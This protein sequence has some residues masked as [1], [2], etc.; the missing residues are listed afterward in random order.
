MPIRSFS[1]DARKRGDGEGFGSDIENIGGEIV[2][3]VPILCLDDIDCKNMKSSNRIR[4][5]PDSNG[6]QV[7]MS[8]GNISIPNQITAENIVLTSDEKMKYQIKDLPETHLKIL[9]DILPKQ[10]KF[11][12]DQKG[13]IHFGFMAQDIEKKFPQMVLEVNNVKRVNYIE[14]IPLLFLKYRQLE[15]KLRQLEENQ[16]KK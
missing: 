16:I 9:Q 2:F 10:F 7:I 14:M 1:G 15:N 8:N 5:A 4:G 3:N 12:N 6:E 11:K 13:E